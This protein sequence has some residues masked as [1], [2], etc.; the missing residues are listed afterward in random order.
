MR[1]YEFGFAASVCYKAQSYESP[2]GVMS[3]GRP[4]GHNRQRMLRIPMRGYESRARGLIR[5]SSL[6]YESPCGVMRF[7][8]AV[9]SSA[10]VTLRI[11]MRGYETILLGTTSRQQLVTNPHAGL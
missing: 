3:M 6:G 7:L 4:L 2:C 11:P 8:A 9:V 5:L 10:T 1:G